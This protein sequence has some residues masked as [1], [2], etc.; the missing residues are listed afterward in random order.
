MEPLTKNEKAATFIG[1]QSTGTMEFVRGDGTRVI[2]RVNDKGRPAPVMSMAE[3]LLAALMA[4]VNR[5]QWGMLKF[6]P[7]GFEMHV[8]DNATQPGVETPVRRYPADAIID[9]LANLYDK[10]NPA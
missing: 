7:A 6:W 5:K 9:A 4:L 1:W 8:H 3:N 10:E 2:W